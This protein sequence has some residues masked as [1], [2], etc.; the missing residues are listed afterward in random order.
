[1][2]RYLLL[3]VLLPGV[4]INFLINLQAGRMLFPV[5]RDLPLWG[6]PGMALDTLGGAFLIGFFTLLV[7]VPGARR[8][9]RAGRV[10]G[11]GRRA[12]WLA[13]PA[14]RPVLSALIG[15]ALCALVL[16]GPLVL[17]WA[18]RG[19]EAMPRQDFIWFKALSSAAIGMVPGLVAAL[20]G[21]APEADATADPRWCRDPAA[22]PG[23]HYPC[24]YL[25]KGG[26]AVTDRA[27]GCSATPTWDLEVRGALQPEHVRAA[28]ADLVLRYPSLA[29]RVQA[30]DGAPPYARRYR[31]GHDPGFAVDAIFAHHDLRGQDA[32]AYA[33]LL[34]EHQN[35]YLDL[36]TEAPLTLTLVRT[37]D[38]AC[39]LLFRQHHAIADGRAFIALL[40]DFTRYLEA[41]RAGRRPDPAALAPIGRR[42]ELEA[43]GLTGTQRVGLTLAGFGRLVT[44]SWRA[45]LR[46]LRPLKQNASNDYSGDNGTVHWVVDDAALARWKAAGSAAGASVNSWLTAALLAATQRW[47]RAQ[48]LALGRTSATMMMET[49]PRA[50]DFVSFANHLASLEVLTDLG[51]EHTLPEL[52]RTVQAQVDAQRR[53]KVPIKR[54]LIERFFV[55]VL[56]VDA[57]AKLVFESKRPSRSLDFSNLIALDF[58][59]LGGDGWAIEDVRITTPVVPRAGMVLTVIRYRGRLTFN[60]NYKST[61]ISRADVE[62]FAGHFAAVLEA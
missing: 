6:N 44:T 4:V 24:Q 26:L 28:L 55:G 49:R 9:A 61:A 56:P 2:A 7:V 48:G 53:R 34:R 23:P 46:P 29:T 37:A 39:H 42:D 47:H 19:V 62:T 21:V 57:L 33:A 60:F 14:R 25:D 18:L 12:R 3:L 58:P 11:W 1:V 30:L 5:G 45:A 35:R 15:G 50:A 52:A 59:A 20:L 17:G 8:E 31:Y 41:A 22:G 13:L 36:Y 27:R 43:L 54:Y 16:G 38:E 10:R 32:A 51:R 40:G